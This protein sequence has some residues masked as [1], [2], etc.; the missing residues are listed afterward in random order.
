MLKHYKLM[1]TK[2]IQYDTL[3][4]WALDRGSTFFASLETGKQGS[5]I[6]VD[7]EVSSFSG[8]L[9]MISA[10]YPKADEEV[11][12]ELLHLLRR[13]ANPDNEQTT[14]SVS[15]AWG[16]NAY[17]LVSLLEDCFCAS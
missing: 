17:Y 16:S 6:P 5:A 14:Y 1:D 9:E 12:I 4:H 2:Q 13:R 8:M 15:Q 11:C 10:W 3:A 7:S